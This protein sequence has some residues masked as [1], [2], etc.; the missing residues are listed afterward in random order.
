M[1]P[2]DNP[3]DPAILAERRAKRAEIAEEQLQEQLAQ[4]RRD[5]DRLQGRADALSGE[6][7]L[8]RERRD[9][10]AREIDGLKRD[11][12]YAHQREHSERQLRIET[13]D[14]LAE[15]QRDALGSSDELRAELRD[16]YQR[17]EEF[18]REL[19]HRRR[20]ADLAQGLI[21]RHEVARARAEQA[22]HGADELRTELER[23][24]ALQSAFAEQMQGLRDEVE[25]MRHSFETD[26]ARLTLA[27][28][29]MRDVMAAAARMRERLEQAELL[30]AEAQERL[31]LTREQLDERDAQYARATR[32]LEAATIEAASLR[33]QL[34]SERERTASALDAADAP[35]RA[36]FPDQAAV[37]EQIAA[38]QAMLEEVAAIAADVSARY[39][40]EGDR[41]QARIDSERDRHEAERARL[42]AQL[43]A[44]PPSPTDADAATVIA[45]LSRAAQRLRDT[46]EIP[47]VPDEPRDEE[48]WQALPG[49]RPAEPISAW[50]TPALTALGQS[51]TAAA[52]EILVALL[53]LQGRTS[54]TLLYELTIPGS[55]TWRVSLHHEIADITRDARRS[56]D[57]SAAF[58]LTGAPQDVAVLAGGGP[59][60]LGPGAKVTGKR[61]RAR[62]LLKAGRDPVGLADAVLLLD[63]GQALALLAA[64]RIRAKELVTHTFPLSRVHEGFHALERRTGDPVKVIFH[65]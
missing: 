10:T 2:A 50:L 37:K 4:A 43:A 19:R 52:T 59:A 28:T 45:D 40:R 17:A 35:L 65:P 46:A 6:L 34:H 54:Q 15:A 3:I 57:R 63:P 1:F 60:R 44:P 21:A 23:R 64:G 31:T 39:E 47:A 62:K 38:L 16:A 26:Q 25:A 29:A 18:E 56:Y 7:E 30:R 49:R 11:L 41:V 22:A 27:Q 20:D 48:D 24:A 12:R 5:I 8:A 53:A 32:E 58:H 42:A 33:A 14:V 55:G 36:H 9:E 51:D 13:Q 61:R